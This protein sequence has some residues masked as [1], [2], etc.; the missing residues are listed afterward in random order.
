VEEQLDEGRMEET[1]SS[2]SL[3]IVDFSQHA[4]FDVDDIVVVPL[5][6]LP[7]IL[8]CCC[9]FLFTQHAPRHESLHCFFI[10]I[11]PAAVSFV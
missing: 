1:E 6:S 9:F 7:Q 5:I 4:F 2:F 3:F 8:T 11:P 10:A